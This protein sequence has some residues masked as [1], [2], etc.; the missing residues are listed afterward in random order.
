VVG[1]QVR[2][3]AQRHLSDWPGRV[4]RQVRRQHADPE[5]TLDGDNVTRLVKPEP[6]F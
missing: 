5:L 1:D 4:I 6:V 3:A 2:G